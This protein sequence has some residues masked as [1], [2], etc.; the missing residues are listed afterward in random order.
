MDQPKGPMLGLTVS[1]D[2]INEALAS[3]FSES[4]F[5]YEVEYNVSKYS[6]SLLFIITFLSLVL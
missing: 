6:Y 5:V 2:A 3:W 4:Y 1:E